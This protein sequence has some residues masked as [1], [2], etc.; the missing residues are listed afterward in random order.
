MIREN[1]QTYN[2]VITGERIYECSPICPTI[3]HEKLFSYKKGT[4]NFKGRQCVFALLD[5]RIGLLAPNI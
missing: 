1:V 5:N 3:C 4:R 2:V